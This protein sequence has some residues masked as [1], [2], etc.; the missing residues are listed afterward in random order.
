MS[1]KLPAWPSPV[2][3]C[4]ILFESHTYAVTCGPRTTIATKASVPRTLPTKL[5]CREAES[6]AEAETV[7]GAATAPE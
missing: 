3:H 1:V 7:W 2:N 5:L 6:R 4:A